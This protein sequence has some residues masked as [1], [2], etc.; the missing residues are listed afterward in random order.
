MTGAGNARRE[1]KLPP[2]YDPQAVEQKLYRFWLEGGY[3]GARVNRAR[4]PFC[5][6]IPPP[7]VTGSLHIGHALDNTMQDILIRWRRMQGFEA[8][9][10][11]GT[12]H[13][14]IATQHV[15][16]KRLA[17]E[18]TTRHELGRERF[19]ERVWAWKD[20]YEATILSQ[21]RRLGASCDWTRTRFTMDEGCSR[22]VREV[23][24]SLWEKGLVYRGDY[25]INWCPECRTALSDLEVE[26]EE[27]TGKLWYVRYPFADGSGYITVA[28]TRPETILG[29]V[30]VAVHPGDPRY[31][32]VVGKT[33]VVP[34]VERPV[35]VIEDEAVDPAFGTGAVK[36][37]PAHDPDDFLTGQRHQLPAPLVIGA[38]G[39]MTQEAGRYAGLTREECRRA[40]LADLHRAGLVDHEE[41]HVMARGE[42][43]R[44]RTVVEPLLSRQWF[45]RMRPLA[46][47]AME[48]VKNGDIVIVPERFTRVY[49]NWLEN[50][51][52]W[53]I[54]RQIWWGHRVPA[55]YC[56]ECGEITVSRVDPTACSHCGSH[57]LEQDEN[58]LDTWFSSALWPFS[59]LGWP[60][61]TPELE[62]FYPTSVLVTGYDILF[63]W[64]A[65]MIFMGLEFMGQRPFR[66]VLLHG[67]VRDAE[68][69]KMSKSKGTGIDPMDAVDKYGADSLRFSLITGN[70][71]GNDMRFSWKKLEGARNFCNKIWN[72]AR[73]VLMNLE[74]FDPEQRGIPGLPERW[75][76]SRYAKVRDEA[77][78]YLEAF[79]LGE[80]A[81]VL[82]DF[83]WDEFCDW[84]IEMA[85][86][87]LAADGPS[88]SAAQRTL[89]L[90]LEGSMRLLHPFLPFLTEE[91]WQKLPHEGEALVR[92]SWPGA[93]LDLVDPEAEDTV[94]LWMEVTR[95]VRTLRA[96][97]GIGPGQVAPAI[98]QAADAES[99][100]RLTA[101]RDLIA[102][103]SWSDPLRVFREGQR[104]EKAMAAVVRGAEVFLPFEG[105]LDVGREIERTEKQLRTAEAELA[106]VRGRLADEGFLRK[107]PP[108]VV[109]ETREREQEAAQRVWKLEQRL[110]ALQK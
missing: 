56:S 55:W 71:P 95:A 68:G 36:I 24:V 20:E 92:A 75:I 96:E 65:R 72:A 21:L 107:A 97:I 8:L 38:D 99:M 110:H 66:H 9:W 10:V 28:T 88:R 45:V 105:W 41:D 78:A 3:F 59:T 1:A 109:E 58:V 26:R 91:I 67:L 102:R 89:W 74:D 60:E 69:Q 43:Y 52:D 51:R 61:R 64:V 13:A 82:Y 63:F 11:P 104:P 98:V 17:R 77:T 53:C 94:S 30:A 27:T 37:T 70:T 33:V 85:K 32:Q 6:V 12:D 106:R 25:I 57:R 103:L 42:C 76:L 14:G 101:G 23:F 54:S 44:C 73:F 90:V 86:E 81:R 16:E 48:A 84:Y 49:L 100:R 22:A 50:I 19:L 15:V 7:N 2:V 79:E 83:L 93:R 40:I 31:R 29:D 34:M 80:A 5:I 62:Y 46:E 4:R 18:G 35:P 108:E 47:P 87:R 39:T